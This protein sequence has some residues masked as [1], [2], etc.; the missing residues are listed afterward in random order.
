MEATQHHENY[1]LSPNDNINDSYVISDDKRPFVCQTC[2]VSFAREKAL[3][4][5]SR[6]IILINLFFKFNL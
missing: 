2:G 6:V 3:F 4:S 5:H 1:S